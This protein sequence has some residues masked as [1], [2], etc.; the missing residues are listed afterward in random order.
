VTTATAPV[1]KGAR[2]LPSARAGVARAATPPAEP[3]VPSGDSPV[4]LE[5]LSARWQRALDAAGSALEAAG[6]S[7]PASELRDRRV[8]LAR[9]S[10]T[11]AAS[12]RE[13][14]RGRRQPAPWLSPTPV[15]NRMLGLP[16]TVRACLFDVE[17]VLSDSSRLHAWAWGE[18]FDD[19][20]SRVAA[21]TRWQFVPFDRVAD[22]RT[23]VTGR[24]RLEGVHTFLRSRGIGVPEGRAGDPSDADTAHGLARLKGELVERRLHEQGVT[25]LPGVRRYLEAAR[26]AGLL[27]AVVYESA[28]TLPMLE[29]AALA[30]LVDARIDAAVI[31]AEDLHSRPA[32]DLLLAACRRLEVEPEH[33]VTFT[34]TGAGVVAGRRAGMLT[35]GVGDADQSG[36]LESFGADQ[37]VATLDTL[38]DPRL[39]LCG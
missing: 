34:N 28:S 6:D 10:E 27:R 25:A 13:L 32:P 33:A 18:V 16:A 8:T 39:R 38:L 31:G 4:D 30:S 1:R 9:E 19:Y 36:S 23:Y 5:L 26:R 29:Q 20:L 17:G 22:Y 11:T 37:V 14:A 2:R 15:T 12:L 35:I 21:A 3:F 7:L 24:S